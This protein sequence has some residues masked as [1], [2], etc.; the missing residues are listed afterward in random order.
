MEALEQ[1]YLVG[2]HK[3]AVCRHYL[4]PVLYKIFITNVSYVLLIENILLPVDSGIATIFKKFYSPL[5]SFLRLEE[6]ENVEACS[7]SPSLVFLFQTGFQCFHRHFLDHFY[8]RTLEKSL[9]ELV[10]VVSYCW[11][12]CLILLYLL[13]QLGMSRRLPF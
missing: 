11:I 3:H 8:S 4:E 13:P 1:I 10:A 7:K 5:L 9:F 12:G 6:E 2:E